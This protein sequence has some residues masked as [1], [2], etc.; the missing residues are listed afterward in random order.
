[1]PYRTYG[2]G[3]LLVS[4]DLDQ[5]NDATRDLAAFATSFII[6]AHDALPSGL[7]PSP[8]AIV[9]SGS[10]L[11]LTIGGPGQGI[12]ITSRLINVCPQVV[13][14][15]PAN[16]SGISRTD[17]VAVQYV[18]TSTAPQTPRPIENPDTS[19]NPTG[20]VYSVLEAVQYQYI[21]GSTTAPVG[22]TT[23]ATILVP[24]GAT[25]ASACTVTIGFVTVAELLQSFFGALVLGLNGQT[26]S[27]LL[28]SANPSLVVSS[29]TPGTVEL[30][31]DGPTHVNGL[32]GDISVE[33]TSGGIGVTT[34]GQDII[35]TNTG[36]THLNGYTGDTTV[37]A[38]AGISVTLPGPG[39]TEIINAGV[40]F[41]DGQTGSIVLT[42]SDS[43]ISIVNGAGTIDLG[44]NHPAFPPIGGVLLHQQRVTNTTSQS[45]SFSSPLSIGTWSLKA[46]ANFNMNSSSTVTLTGSSGTW[47]SP[48]STNDSD[49]PSNADLY[50]LGTAVAGQTPSVTLVSTI[51]SPYV[52]Y[53]GIFEIVATR[54]S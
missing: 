6:G 37:T 49:Q 44:I 46:H 41:L 47:E 9:S 43:S 33:S 34:V 5:D 1:M 53:L 27:V 31:Y 12:F 7:T 2:D 50:L 16:S 48:S 28:T 15:I 52:G 42:S 11:T 26:G 32:T 4:A 13:L 23:F 38:G 22:W 8:L 51:G 18:E 54:V 17:S 24:N 25:T 21:T 35:I 3:E 30:A 45:I 39:V 29:P 36:V 14:T 19:I 40:T 10:A 20:T